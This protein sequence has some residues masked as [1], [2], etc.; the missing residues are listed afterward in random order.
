MSEPAAWVRC[1]ACEDFWCTIHKR[2]VYDCECPPLE[3]WAED[4][5]EIGISAS[6]DDK[7]D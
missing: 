1:P 3:E 5:Y 4:P 7:H 6:H 2:H